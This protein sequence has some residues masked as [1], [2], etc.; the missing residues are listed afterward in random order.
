MTSF[1]LPLPT[2]DRDR[3]RRLLRDRLD[4]WLALSFRHDILVTRAVRGVQ[5]EVGALF[6]REVVRPLLLA[7]ASRLPQVQL[8]SG[9]VVA[10]L[11]PE[12]VSLR[13][14][15]EQ[16]IGT[17]VG[18]VRRL[19]EDR[20][21]EIAR[22]EVRWVDSAA[23]RLLGNEF[24]AGVRLVGDAVE[25]RVVST[26][27][28]RVWLGDTTEK[29][30]EK[31]LQRPTADAARAWV[32]TGVQQN[33]SVQEVARELTGTRT[34]TGIL[35]SPR[36]T[37]Q[38]L[39]RTAS[40]HATTAA[41][42]EGF[43]E[44]GVKYWRFVATLDLRTTV[45]CASQD[46]RVHPIGEGPAPPLHVNCRSVAVPIGSRDEE[47][48]GKRA[49]LGG[50]VPASKTFEQWLREQPA[51]DQD[52]VLGKAKGAAWRAGSLSM[53][54]MLGRDLQPLTLEELRRLDRL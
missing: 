42:M 24:G 50:Q 13:A 8:R 1:A 5:I 31:A 25:R 51:A 22:G 52:L 40:T 6:E 4:E 49:A 20:L 45:Q 44:L 33:L 29:W 11:F 53:R 27:R 28:D 9:D 21:A 32:T 30:F 10:D 38:A 7:V 34:Q 2:A 41:R 36:H 37:A 23:R 35:D 46:G 39:V 26:L 14:A 12:L 16:V 19:T 3:F 17:G 43:K 54:D 48:I 15:V 18:A 47:P